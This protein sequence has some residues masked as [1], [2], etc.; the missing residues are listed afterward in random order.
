M[1]M[2]DDADMV[3]GIDESDVEF[4][5]CAA[6][7]GDCAIPPVAGPGTRPERVVT[8]RDKARPCPLYRVHSFACLIL[9][10]VHNFLVQPT[11]VKLT[12]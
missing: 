10:R 9:H 11:M 12:D 8:R 6:N 2:P 7:R 1:P 5:C 4:K 3:L